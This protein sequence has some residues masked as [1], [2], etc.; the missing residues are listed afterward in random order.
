MGLFTE[1]DREWGSAS[2]SGWI[3]VSWLRP[4]GV[5]SGAQPA[6]ACR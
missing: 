5:A 6:E 1:L 2:A 4:G 3:P